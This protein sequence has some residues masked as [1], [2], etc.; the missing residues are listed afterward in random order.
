MVA[1]HPHRRGGWRATA[2]YCAAEETFMTIRTLAALAV[3]ALSAPVVAQQPPAQPG[4]FFD[5]TDTNKDGA[6]SKA[7]WEAAGRRPE[8]FAMM[9]SNKDGKVTKAEGQAAMQKMMQMRSQQGQ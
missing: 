4:K 5:A 6:L 8:G 3:L 2:A 9:D 7:E 1:K